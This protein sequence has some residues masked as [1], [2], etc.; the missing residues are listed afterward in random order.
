MNSLPSS[1][2]AALVAVVAFLY[3][4]VGFGGASGYLAV[5]SQ[6]GIDPAIMASTALI[7]NIVVASIAFINYT[8]A[9]HLV[10]RLLIP[11]LLT[12]VPAAFLGGYFKLTDEAYYLLLYAMLTYVMLRM[13]FARPE[14]QSGAA[15]LRLF[16]LWLAL[17]CGAGIGLLSGIV[18]IGGGVFLSPLIILARWGT[19]KQAA[20][21]AAGF[22]VLNSI[23]G[24]IGRAL[25]GN[26][27]LG[28]FGAALLPFGII[29]ALA[30][31]YL[32]ARHFSGLW[33][34]RIL[35]VV[36]LIAI[37]NFVVGYLKK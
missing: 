29:G 34:R 3:A 8:R 1:L 24:L 13:L 20:A 9:G 28:T 11:F 27:V 7:L 35:G 19:P 17:V 36:L 21:T 26:F 4:S 16:P 14:P 10:K 37:V 22:I 5:M 23:S 25:G 15:D 12:S 2:L 32:G 6:F 18:G 31:S 30:G 33:T